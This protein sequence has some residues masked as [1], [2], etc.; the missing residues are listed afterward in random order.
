MSHA[1][2]SHYGIV[3]LPDS[4]EM[5]LR[6]ERKVVLV[7]FASSSQLIVI[8]KSHYYV[9]VHVWH[10]DYNDTIDFVQSYN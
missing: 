10:C 8:L 9:Q 1:T 6:V 4:S 5:Y 7:V 2:T 3:A